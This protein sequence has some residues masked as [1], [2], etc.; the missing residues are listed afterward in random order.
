MSVMG[1]PLKRAA[2]RGSK[3][4]LQKAMKYNRSRKLK[5]V[6]TKKTARKPVKETS[7]GSVE[8][9]ERRL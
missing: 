2:N 4:F 9:T 5:Q 1:T 3:L 7:P 8:G 6:E